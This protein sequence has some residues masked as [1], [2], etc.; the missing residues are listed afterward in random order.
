MAV[1][2]TVAGVSVPAGSFLVIE[3]ANSPSTWHLQVKDENGKP[4]HGLMGAAW[5]AL[6]GGYRG[7]RYEGPQK[8]AAIAKLKKMYAG[9]NMMNPDEQMNSN[10]RGK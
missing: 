8:E 1:T 6:H 4:S 7:N 2:K 3:D 10:I 5:A 9:E